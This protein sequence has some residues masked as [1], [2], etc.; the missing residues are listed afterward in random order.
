[1]YNG[2]PGQLEYLSYTL[3]IVFLIQLIINSLSL[4]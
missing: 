2:A 4:H 3:P 1:M